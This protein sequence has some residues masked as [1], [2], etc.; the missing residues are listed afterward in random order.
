MYG[1]VVTDENWPTVAGSWAL[2]DQTTISCVPTSQRS[3]TNGTFS[4]CEDREPDFTASQKA[5]NFR[6]NVGSITSHVRK[7]RSKVLEKF[8]ISVRLEKEVRQTGCEL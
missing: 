8:E 3:A 6:L 7:W 5:R 1:Q 2:A 4:R